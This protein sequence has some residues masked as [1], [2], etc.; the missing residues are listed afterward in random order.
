MVKYFLGNNKYTANHYIIIRLLTTQSTDEC[1]F[2]CHQPSEI[3]S[4]RQNPLF[5]LS[6]EIFPPVL[7]ASVAYLYQLLK[8]LI[9]FVISWWPTA[10]VMPYMDHAA[11]N[12]YQHWLLSSTWWRHQMETFSALLAICAGNSPVSGEFPAQRP[13]A[14][15]FDVFFDLCPINDW[16]NNREAGDLRRS[17]AHYDVIVMHPWFHEYYCSSWNYINRC[18]EN[19][20]ITTTLQWRYVIAIAAPQF[21]VNSAVCSIVCYG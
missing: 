4:T 8:I 9:A 3:Y 14:R 16:V 6:R 5:Q 13:V 10:L 2:M 15:S 1:L 18:N 7:I 19:K 20:T 17:R 11:V 21:A 12:V